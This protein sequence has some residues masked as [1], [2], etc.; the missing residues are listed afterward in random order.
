MTRGCVGRTL[1]MANLLVFPLA[2]VIAFLAPVL[3]I[4]ARS[5]LYLYLPVFGVCLLAG[6][7]AQALIWNVAQ[8]RTV[9]V[10]VAVYVVTLGAYQ[11]VRGIDI[12]RDL[13][14][15]ER[16]VEAIRHNP[17]VT[18]YQGAALLVMPADGT[19][20]R[21]LQ[22]AI[23]GYLPL[24]LQHALGSTRLTGAV[25]YAGEASRQADLRLLCEYRDGDVR[26]TRQ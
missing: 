13:V 3:P 20:E 7:L 9:A 23:G 14:F 6:V 26:L 18:A 25:Q 1:I 2:W 19:T 15:S 12:R 11:V 4:V 16:L 22:D 10:V 8:R 17:E 5:E 21:F 24:V